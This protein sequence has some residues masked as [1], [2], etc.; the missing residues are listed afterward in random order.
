MSTAPKPG[1]TEAA[2]LDRVQRVVGYVPVGTSDLLRVLTHPDVLPLTKRHIRELD[3]EG[4]K[5]PHV[6]VLEDGQTYGGLENSTILDVPADL[7]GDDYERYIAAHISEDGEPVVPIS[8]LLGSVRLA[9]EAKGL[10][11]VVDDVIA[12]VEDHVVDRYGDE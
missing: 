7:E 6:I 9:L 8:D 10:G 12:T 2:L 3:N 1:T 4:G 11:C 5:M